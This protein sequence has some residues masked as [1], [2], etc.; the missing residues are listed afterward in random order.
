MPRRSA[1]GRVDL[2]RLAG[3]AL[4]LVRRQAVQR[5][6]VVEAVGQ[7]DQDD[8]DVLGHGQ[9]HLSDVLGLL[10][11]VAVGAE[12]RQ[13]RDAVDELGDLAAEAL[14]D[15][16]QAVF[17][18]LGDVVQERGLD[19]DRVD[20]E[21]G[22]DLGRGDRVRDVGLTRRTALAGVRLDGQVEGGIDRREVRGRVVR[23]DRRV[24]GRAQGLE[25]DLAAGRRPRQ[26]LGTPRPATLRRL[27]SRRLL[28]D[29]G[30]RLVGGH[31]GRLHRRLLD[32][33]RFSRGL[34]AG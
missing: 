27:R 22:H 10:L 32:G 33:G 8:P 16:G 23:G 1:S 3:D 29:D 13:L 21:L 24:E 28:D 20:A 2:H 9:E 4:L 18:V 15:V 14:L 19:R 30:G 34:G 7:L 12:P 17:G 6:H 26:D 25:V 11:L 31:R 5:A